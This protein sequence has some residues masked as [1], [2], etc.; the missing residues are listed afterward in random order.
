MKKGICIASAILMISIVLSTVFLR[1]HSVFDVITAFM[2]A[3]VMYYLVYSRSF[4]KFP[5]K[6]KNKNEVVA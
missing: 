2:V 3:G 1:Q 5:A 6:E 4:C